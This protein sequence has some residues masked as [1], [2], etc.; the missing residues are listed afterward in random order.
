MPI[1]KAK[2]DSEVVTIEKAIKRKQLAEENGSAK[3]EFRCEA[4]DWPVSAH[5]GHT[6]INGVETRAHFE[7]YPENDALGQKPACPLAN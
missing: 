6:D 2:H 3:P 7:H 4:C 5:P 1:F